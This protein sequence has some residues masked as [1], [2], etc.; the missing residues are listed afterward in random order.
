MEI[1]NNVKDLIDTYGLKITTIFFAIIGLKSFI[2]FL[3]E[4]LFENYFITKKQIKIVNLENEINRKTM[5][6]KML[7]ENELEFYNKYYSFAS[8]I[9][10]DIQDVKY[11]LSNSNHKDFK[12]YTLKIIEVIPKIKREL[13]LYESYC[14]KNVLN[15][16]TELIKI[17]QKEFLVKLDTIISKNKIKGS[18]NELDDICDKVVMQL[19]WIST[20]IC[21]REKIM[22][23][24]E[25]VIKK[26]K[27]IKIEI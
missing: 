6:Y 7:I 1:I 23:G 20:L 27:K 26:E 16:I 3:V 18:E 15:A 13:L 21:T 22:S 24:Q 4:K 8:N 5:A 2:K 9:V 25:L 11:T 10:P 14:D 17:L 19:A 12:K